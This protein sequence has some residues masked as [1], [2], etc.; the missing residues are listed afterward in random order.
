V[1]ICVFA[2]V[3]IRV[4][5]FWKCGSMLMAKKQFGYQCCAHIE[6]LTSNE[7]HEHASCGSDVL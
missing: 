1:S 4:R 5:R 3:N 6:S 2:S 7:F